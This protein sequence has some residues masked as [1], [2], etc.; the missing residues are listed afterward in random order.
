MTNLTKEKIYRDSKTSYLK[1]SGQFF[2]GNLI[3]FCRRHAGKKI[4]DLGCACG[5]YC[6]ELKRLGFECAGADI[7]EE[8]V[9]IAK[10]KGVEAHAVGDTLP[11]GDRSFDTVVMFELLEHVRD[12]GR[13]LNEAGRVARKNILITVPDCG[14]F[15]TLKKNQLT[16]EHFLELDHINFFTKKELEGV[17]SEYFKKFNVMRKEAVFLGAFGLPWWIRKPVRLLYESGLL[18]PE[19]YNRLYAIVEM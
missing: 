12:P 11:F 18:K 15:E 13:I 7:N 19:I 8:Y 9:K 14:G 16:Y 10:G 17:L 4:L 6:V 2:S 1:A 3:N 5:D